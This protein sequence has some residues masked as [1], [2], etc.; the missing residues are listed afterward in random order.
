[1]WRFKTHRNVLGL[2]IV[3]CL[4]LKGIIMKHEWKKTEKN[5]Y[6]PK[7][8]PERIVIPAFKFFTIEGA[9]NPND[10][11]FAEYIGVLYSLSYGVKMTVKKEQGIDYAVY[12][13]EGIW[14]ISEDAK[15]NLLEKS[16]KMN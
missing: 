14:D 3:F 13:L 10:S 15:K 1:M 9:G 8:K 11:Y 16:I 2:S 7:A 5:F 4:N 6:L 12:P